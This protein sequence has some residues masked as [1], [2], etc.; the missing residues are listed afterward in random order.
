[1]VLLTQNGTIDDFA[2]NLTAIIEGASGIL[3][4]SVALGIL[5][6]S[7]VSNEACCNYNSCRRNT[8]PLVGLI[9]VVI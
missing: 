1:M 7:L 6:I 4:S 5:F 9:M 3:V 2:K 8:F